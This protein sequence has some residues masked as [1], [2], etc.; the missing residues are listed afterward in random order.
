MATTALL[1]TVLSSLFWSG[2]D[3]TRKRLAPFLPPGP[4][5]AVLMF[6][7]L[8]VFLVLGMFEA[9]IEPT[10]GLWLPAILSIALN[11]AANILFLKSVALAPLSLAVPMLSF[12]PVFG[13]ICGYLALGETLSARQT[14]GIVVVILGAWVLQG[15]MSAIFRRE[16]AAKNSSAD[17]ARVNAGAE[18]R[19]IRKG[20]LL[21][22][23]VAFFWSLTPVVDKLGLRHAN[24]SLYAFI[25]CLG[26]ALAVVIYSVINKSSF[27]LS[28]FRNHRLD[29][30]LAALTGALALATQFVAVQAMAVGLFEALKRAIGLLASLALGA[31]FFQEKITPEKISGVICMGI[32]I[33]LIL[34]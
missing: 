21:M 8:P 31:I 26:I 22:T 5:V 27:A 34:I 4:V 15:G 1:I 30:G 6:A 29:L 17:A 28:A 32:G 10:S 23:I 20:L 24:V 2:F 19:Q 7:Q 3:L 11:L 18:Q 12:T 9:W 25:Q 33:A 13:A 16:P 14:F